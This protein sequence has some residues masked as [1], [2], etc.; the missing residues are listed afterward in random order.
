MM[1]T[2]ESLQTTA[3]Y[4]AQRAGQLEQQL[5]QF[6]SQAEEQLLSREQLAEQATTANMTVD[7]EQ[8]NQAEAQQSVLV[9]QNSLAGANQQLA[10]AQAAQQQ[11]SSTQAE[12]MELNQLEAWSEAANTFPEQLQ[13]TAPG[14]QYFNQPT[15]IPRS[16]FLQD[17]AV[18]R[19]TV[20][21]QTEGVRLDGEVASAQAS[22]AV[23]QAELG[24]ANAQ[25][26]VADQRVAIAQ[27]QAQFAAF[28]V[29]FVDAK[30]FSARLW[31][32]LAIEAKRLTSRY[33]DLAIEAALRMQDAY[34]LETGRNLSIIQFSYG[35]P[36]ISD[37]LA[38]DRLMLDIDSFTADYQRTQSKRA[39][40]KQV[41]SIGD[42]FP[43]A[44]AALKQQGVATFETTLE[45]FERP[46]PGFYL[47]KLRNVE[48]SFV[49][50]TGPGGLSGTLRNIGVAKFRRDNNVVDVLAYP[51]EVMPLSP[52][53]VRQDALVFRVSPNEQRIFEN[54][55]LATHWR[56]E[57]PL[58][59]NDMDFDELL[60]VYLIFEYDALFSAQ[61]ETQVRA[62]L[63]TTGTGA[64]GISL[65]LYFPDELFYL[66]SR[67]AAQL[68][69]DAGMF[70]RNQLNLV[71]NQ[72]VVQALGDAAT[73]GGLTI[74][75]ASTALG[76][77]LVVKL[78]NTGRL[79]SKAAGS[80]LAPLVGRPLF[81]E[82]NVTID[83]ADNPQLVRG[84][85]L[86]LSGLT[87]VQLYFEY[88]FTYR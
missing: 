86:D 34:N 69:F 52:Y 10:N 14:F 7:L 15:L 66:K 64:R 60:D 36:G 59:A 25:S 49:G 37:L 43:S 39:P 65:R 8:R 21:Q 30:Q 4:L 28:N 79:D 11:F 55:A 32:D 19:T 44:L 57:V 63:P 58:A 12:M 40:I 76:G 75:I 85:S 74:R 45:Q 42:I 5:I 51:P 70:P 3:R 56:L 22:L 61:L 84:G 35:N 81:D 41:I 71:R 26:A 2:F 50:I 47:H 46:Y 82:W 16:Q 31:F 18:K 88:G 83:P 78:D 29:A 53:D 13:N 33:L 73:I 77:V 68:V 1:Q 27:V 6:K 38:S 48:V 24:Q 17:L 72:V 62:A 87:D 9:A 20:D 23:S 80:P 67:G 54:N